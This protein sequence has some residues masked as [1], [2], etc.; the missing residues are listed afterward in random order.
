MILITILFGTEGNLQKLTKYL[1][2]NTHC[3]LLKKCFNKK[4][5]TRLNNNNINKAFIKSKYYFII[6]I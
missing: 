3:L 5:E 4:T 1:Q 2:K 6:L